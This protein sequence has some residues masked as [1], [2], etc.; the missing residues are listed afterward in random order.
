MRDQHHSIT[1]LA[2]LSFFLL[3]VG[4]DP[5]GE[6]RPSNSAPNP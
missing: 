3:V 1:L 2:V 5:F 6:F 4:R